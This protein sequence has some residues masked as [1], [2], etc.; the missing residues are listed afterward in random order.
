MQVKQMGDVEL[1]A[2][3]VDKHMTVC[4]YE[5]AED[6]VLVKYVLAG[7]QSANGERKYEAHADGA[8]ICVL[9]MT[10][11]TAMHDEGLSREIINRM[12]KQRK[13]AKL[14]VRLQR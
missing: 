5:L 4:G 1:S 9:D 13:A 12:Q 8:V 7:Q 14:N 11:D 3:I 6:D 2:F 10:E